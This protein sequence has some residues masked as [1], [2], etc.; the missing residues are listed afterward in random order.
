MANPDNNKRS[1]EKEPR[2]ERESTANPSQQGA[3][4][5]SDVKQ[6]RLAAALKANLR[7]RKAAN[8][9]GEDG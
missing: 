5:K 4:T 2:K 9:T 3:K 8:Q 6:D 7:R 1:G